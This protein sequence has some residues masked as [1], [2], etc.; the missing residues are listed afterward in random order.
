MPRFR[1]LHDVGELRMVYNTWEAEVEAADE[2]EAR[3]KVLRGDF[4][5]PA[6][7]ICY[8]DEADI[9][10]DDFPREVSIESVEVIE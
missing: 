2:Q 1:V 10:H 8:S 3:K 5:G 7:F 4:P 6:E 9:D